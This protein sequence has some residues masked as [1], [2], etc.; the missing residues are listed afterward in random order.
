M[1]EFMDRCFSKRKLKV[2]PGAGRIVMR[3][4][5]ILDLANIYF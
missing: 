4:S 3:R 1:T 5:I 2:R